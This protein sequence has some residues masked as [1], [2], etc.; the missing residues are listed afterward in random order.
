M[1]GKIQGILKL[2]INGSPAAVEYDILSVY[3][4]T[5]NLYAMKFRFLE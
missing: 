3:G 2:R 5:I 1:S 4:F